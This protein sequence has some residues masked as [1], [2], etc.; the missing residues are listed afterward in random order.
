MLMR[1][2]VILVVA[3]LGSVANGVTA[4][5]RA[6]EAPVVCPLDRAQD[7][8]D[9]FESYLKVFNARDW[10]AFTATLDDEIT[11]F[12]DE[13]GPAERIEGRASV[14]SLFRP[15][16]PRGAATSQGPPFQMHPEDVAVRSLEGLA[17][18]SFHLRGENTVSRRT[19]VLTKQA[20]GWRVTH[21]HAS[22]RERS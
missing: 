8:C 5:E 13:P 22:S 20:G 6:R 18:I 1:R 19:L 4:Q 17:V 21:I 14:E 2:V 9:F 16:F 10:Q 12:F 7:V 15:L 3:L 11:V